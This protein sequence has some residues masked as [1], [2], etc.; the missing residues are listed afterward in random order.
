MMNCNQKKVYCYNPAGYGCL[1]IASNN[2]KVLVDNEKLKWHREECGGGYHEEYL[3]LEEIGMQ[4]KD[5][6]YK[7]VFYVWIETP[8]SGV[9]YQFGNYGE[10]KYWIEHGTTKGY[11]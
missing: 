5:L 1:I 9:I 2:E 4:L 11:A 8:L 6:G 10:I 3:T 7:G